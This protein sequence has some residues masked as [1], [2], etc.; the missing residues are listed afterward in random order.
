MLILL[1]NIY[2]YKLKIYK[3]LFVL[4]YVYCLSGYDNNING[5]YFYIVLKQ[6]EKIDKYTTSFIDFQKNIPLLAT[7]AALSF[8]SVYLIKSL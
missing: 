6:I 3:F 4:L 1:Y 7:I 2:S 8:V 5:Y